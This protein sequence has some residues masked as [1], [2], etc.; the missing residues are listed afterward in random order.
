MSNRSALQPIEEGDTFQCHCLNG[1]YAH[2]HGIEKTFSTPNVTLEELREHFEEMGWPELPPVRE[3]YI[4][5]DPELRE[6]PRV[7]PSV[8]QIS[9]A[10]CPKFEMLELPE[11]V[12][13]IVLVDLPSLTTVVAHGRLTSVQIIK[14]PLLSL[15]SFKNVLGT[16]F[17]ISR[18]SW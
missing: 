17:T 5:G 1:N 14:C 2:L 18:T 4:N 3:F 7:L 13:E 6:L 8:E 16:A 15:D 12:V 9:I 11:D 10:Y